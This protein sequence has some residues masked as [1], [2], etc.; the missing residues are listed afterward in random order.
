MEPCRTPQ[1]TLPDLLERVLDKGIMLR[2]DLVIGVAGIPLIGI[3]LHAAIAAIETMLDYGM[4]GSWATETA[5]VPP[6]GTAAG[7]LAPGE[8]TLFETYGSC[9]HGRGVLPG[10]R[11]G[12]LVVTDR[13][14]LLVRPVPAEVL[15][16]TPL[17]AIS[18]VGRLTVDNAGE[19]TREVTCLVLAGGEMAQLYVPE[20]DLLDMALRPWADGPGVCSPVTRPA[21]LTAG[22]YAHA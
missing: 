1:A 19:G 22:G 16:E 18:G 6:G 5:A 14:L 12:R 9:H 3:R 15:F 7:Q 11:P 10:W 4:M 2:L 17:S 20:P 8:R 21:A 13:R